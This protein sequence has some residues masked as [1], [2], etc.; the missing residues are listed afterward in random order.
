MQ[1]TGEQE[2]NG[3]VKLPPAISELEIPGSRT[4]HNVTANTEMTSIGHPETLLEQAE[5][6][7]N[8]TESEQPPTRNPP[9]VN[10]SSITRPRQDR[11]RPSHLKDY[12]LT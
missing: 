6:M 11:R 9:I 7:P 4:P 2:T 5:P 8:G 1:S 10:Q 3:E 12:V